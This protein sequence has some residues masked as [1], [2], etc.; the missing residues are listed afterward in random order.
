MSAEAHAGPCAKARRP[1]TLQTLTDT[2]TAARPEDAGGVPGVSSGLSASFDA[3]AS[4]ASNPAEHPDF[5]L[6]IVD[7]HLASVA[8]V[9]S[10][11]GA[12]A[13]REGHVG[14]RA[15][16]LDE[17]AR[18]LVVRGSCRGRPGPCSSAAAFP[19]RLP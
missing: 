16:R 11:T 6:H 7:T 3:A 8:E 1:V 12:G 19:P 10:S 17:E 5:E 18:W 9:C 2:F 4:C 14:C 15:G 13:A